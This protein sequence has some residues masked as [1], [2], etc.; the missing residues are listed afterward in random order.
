MDTK[1][2]RVRHEEA[3]YMENARRYRER[4]QA[5]DFWLRV[6]HL[7]RMADNHAKLSEDYRARADALFERGVV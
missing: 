4:Q 3:T 5:E 6:R 1:A 2:E 7:D